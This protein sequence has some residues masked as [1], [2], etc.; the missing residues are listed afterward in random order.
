MMVKFI[1]EISGK[2]SISAVHKLMREEKVD[3]IIP[4]IVKIGTEYGDNCAYTNSINYLRECAKE[5]NIVFCEAILLHDEK[6]WNNI[7]IKPQNQL[8]KKFG[9]FSP[10]IMC[11]LFAHLLRI[12][13]LVENKGYGIITGERFSHKGKLK[14][15]QHP[16][17]IKCFNSLFNKHNISLIQ[18]LINIADT[19]IVDKEI[20]DYVLLPHANDVKCILSD[21]LGDFSL[22]T[23]DNLFYLQRYLYEYIYP[24]GDYILNRFL[25]GA[26]VCYD[27]LNG[28]IERCIQ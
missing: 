9:F 2:D 12:P 6:L 8:H 1:A 16:I 27:T 23:D 18:P 22:L 13:I 14:I 25:S 15:N 5:Y 7:C 3:I 11:H 10:C 26:P 19:N 17:T 4:T 28:I 20:E 24:I 21:N